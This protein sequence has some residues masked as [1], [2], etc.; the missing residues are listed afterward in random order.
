MLISLHCGEGCCWQQQFFT[1]LAHTTWA[2]QMRYPK[3]SFHLQQVWP[4]SPPVNHLT[5]YI[6]KANLPD[7]QENPWGSTWHKSPWA[8]RVT[9]QRATTHVTPLQNTFFLTDLWKNEPRISVWLITGIYYHLGANS[10]TAGS[11]GHLGQKSSLQS[12]K[13]IWIWKNNCVIALQQ[14]T[15]N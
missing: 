7:K 9:M 11:S 6:L 8:R 12:F 2:Q 3:P 5:P 14:G 4:R 1:L 15:H 10:G 13:I